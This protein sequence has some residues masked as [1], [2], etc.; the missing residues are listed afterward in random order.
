MRKFVL[1]FL[2]CLFLFQT[3]SGFC[4][5][6]PSVPYSELT[7]YMTKCFSKRKVVGGAVVISYKGQVVFQMPYGKRN[8]SDMVDM[9]TRFRIASI[10]KMISAVGLM[11]LYDQGKIQL[12]A[13]LDD[14]LPFKVR[15][16]SYPKEPITLRQVLSHTS[17]IA[18][19]STYTLNWNNLKKG[20]KY[21]QTNVHPGSKYRYSN[22]NGGLIGTTIEVLSN[23]FVNTYMQENVFE[24]LGMDAGYAPQ[25]LKEKDNVSFIYNTKHRAERSPAHY[26]K[27]GAEYLPVADPIAHMPMTVGSVFVSPLDLTKLMIALLNGG[28]K[29]GV[30]ILNQET[31]EMM[32]KDQRTI[33][34]TTVKGKSAYGLCIAHVDDLEGGTWYGHQG[35]LYGLTSNAYYQKETGL[36]V[37]VIGNGYKAARENYTTKLA[38]DVMTLAT[39]YALNGT[40]DQVLENNAE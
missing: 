13:P 9:E 18:P 36:T 8:K 22:I 12:D 2:V 25:H 28:E 4:K 24:P 37:V 6:E 38:R 20:T 34:G 29:D 35:M 14:V 10:T 23:Q 3:C 19:A 39:D 16:P 30:R 5:E 21:M 17:S 1:Y 33:E 15:N 31:V 26:E 11:Q 7:E 32:E 27:V 40:W